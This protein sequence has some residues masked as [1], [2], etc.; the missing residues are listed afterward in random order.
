MSNPISSVCDRLCANARCVP[1]LALALLALFLA[2]LVRPRE[3]QA[4]VAQQSADAQVIAGVVRDTAGNGI[5]NVTVIVSGAPLP[6]PLGVQT[7][8]RGEFVVSVPA[9]GSYTV[10]VKRTGYAAQQANVGLDVGVSRIVEIELGG[11]TTSRLAAAPNLPL[12]Q[13]F[14]DAA[15]WVLHTDLIYRVGKTKDSVIVPAGFVT[16]FAS[17]PKRLQSF[18]SVHGPYLVAGIVHDYLYWE[19]GAGGCTRAEADGIFRLV[20]MENNATRLESEAMY[21]AVDVAGAGPWNGN[22]ADR[23]AGLIRE[24]PVNRRTIRPLTIWPTYRRTLHAQGLRPSPAR[25]ISRAFCAHGTRD[26]RAVL[27]KL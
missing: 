13:P 25:P 2:T 12:L 10:S 14:S 24:L 8:D 3:G 20:M 23:Q 11:A 26:P 1:R 9:R 4:Q 5:P 7:N 19:Q 21:T 16:D 22:A 17:I 18:F 15:H 27:D 6:A